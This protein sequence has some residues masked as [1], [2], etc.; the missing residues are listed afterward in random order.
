MS[1][2][3]ERRLQRATVE[4]WFSDQ[5]WSVA[6]FQ[7]ALWEAYAAGES[8]LLH[9]PTG[10][11]KTLAAWFGCL[12]AHGQGRASDDAAPAPVTVLWITPLRALA[13]DLEH[14]LKRPLEDLEIGWSVGKRTGDTSS[15]E[16]TRQRRRLPTALITT[17][18]SL[19]LLLSYAE[20]ARQLRQVQAV[21]VDEWHELLGSKRG[22]QL[23]LCLAQLRQQSPELRTWGLSATLGNLSHAMHVL[24]GDRAEAGRLIGGGD[25]QPP[26]IRSALPEPDQR[27]PWSGYTGLMLLPQVVV[28]IEEA[29]STLLFTNT[30]A[31]AERWFEALNGARLDWVGRV[32]LHH[33]S[34]EPKLRQ[35]V[36]ALLRAGELKCVVATS[37]LDLGVDFSPVEQV[38]QVGSPKGVARLLQRA[39]RS[40][41]RPDGISDVLCVPTHAL[42][43]VE[44]AAARSAVQAR[45]IESRTAL[46]LCLDVLA[47]H[48]VTLAVAG[49]VDPAAALAAARS[50]HAYRALTDAQWQWVVLFVTQGGPALAHYPQ[51]QRLEFVEETLRPVNRRVAH[52]HRMAIGTITADASMQVRFQSGGSLG[53]VEESFIAR[54]KPGDAFQFAGRTLELVR[55]RDMTAEV[56]RASARRVAVPRWTGGRLPLSTELADAVQAQLLEFRDAA[57]AGE[58]LVPELASAEEVLRH[59]AAVSALP[60]P[61]ELLLEQ[62]SSRDGHSLF[63]FP[64]AGRLVHEG[65]AA[66]FAYRLSQVEARTFS[67]SIN[68]YGFELLAPEPVPLTE[69]Q[70]RSLFSTQHLLEDIL[71]SVNAAELAKRQFRDIARIAG[72]VFQGFPGSQKSTRQVQASSGLLYD[73]LVR[74]DAANLLPQQALDEL[75]RAQFEFQRLERTLKRC[76]GRQLLLRHTTRLTPLSFP[77]WADRQAT[78]L[79]T[80]SWLERVERM[81]RKLEADAVA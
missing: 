43:L 57:A 19:S 11:G 47:Q 71:A 66:L 24:L 75:L 60:G 45:Q 65:L 40:G 69:P 76:A 13:V 81:Q 3:V 8:G 39:G 53:S 16:R 48:L 7:R 35:G 61:D 15:S 22:V 74:H 10:S 79:S 12:L 27:L 6:S 20:T 29:R 25:A 55:V 63:F 80:E 78:R 38:I 28:A 68:D 2:A 34:L 72:L 64:F 36:E 1:K 67:I 49:G 32:A 44:I 62:T 18:E 70:V 59:Q 50:T 5:G 46:T 30:R 42:E 23:E 56:R 54:L 26:R 4:R 41:H 33:G 31:Q 37:S 58:E 9:S 52:H 77:L 17:P 14:N 73:V 51:F 21:I